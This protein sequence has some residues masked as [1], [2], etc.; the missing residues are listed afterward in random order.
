MFLPRRHHIPC[1][2]MLTVE[3]CAL[4]EERERIVGTVSLPVSEVELPTEGGGGVEQVL[5][6]V[7]VIRRRR[8]E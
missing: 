5:A 3:L 7:D 2:M 1:T 4:L 8:H 6:D